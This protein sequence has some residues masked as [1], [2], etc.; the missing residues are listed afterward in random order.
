MRAINS[1]SLMKRYPLQYRSI[2]MILIAAADKNWAIGRGGDL[3]Y[4]L[5][6]DMRFFRETTMGKT[7]IMGRKTLESM[8]GGRPLKGRRNIILSRSGGVSAEGVEL[9]RSA[10]EAVSLAEASEG[11]VFVIGGE[12]VYRALLPYCDTAYITRVFAESPADRFLPDFDSLPDWD[13]VSRSER[14]E[15]NGIGFEFVTYKRKAPCG[16][17]MFC[18][19]SYF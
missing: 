3:L 2:K 12:E 13:E 4:S 7:V 8:P 16:E 11:E 15:N 10:G 5:P 18:M 17:N 19:Q 9:C 6:D 1:A 14:F